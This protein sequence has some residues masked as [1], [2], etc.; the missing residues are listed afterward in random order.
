MYCYCKAIRSSRAIEASCYDDLG[1]RVIMGN[2]QPDHSTIA[3]FVTGHRVAIKDLLVQTLVIA[4]GD[5]LVSVEVVAGDGTIV[6]ANASMSSNVTADQLDLDIAELHKLLGAEVESWLGEHESN[7]AADQALFG[8]QDDD[9]GPVETGSLQRTVD[10]LLRRRAAKEQLK[11]RQDAR[12]APERERVDK[13]GANVVERERAHAEALA[14][15]QAKNQAWHARNAEGNGMPGS[16]PVQAEAHSVVRRVEETVNRAKARHA[17]AQTDFDKATAAVKI[18]TTDPGSQV[19]K[20]KHGQ[21]EQSRNVQIHVESHQLILHIACHDNSN[22]VDALHPGLRGTRDNLNAAAIT[23]PIGVAL[24][25]A[26][27]ASHENFTTNCPDAETYLLVAT[28]KEARQTGRKKDPPAREPKLDSWLAMNAKLATEQGKALY[29]KRAS[30][31]EPV[32]GQMFG[33]LG[34]YLNYRGN[35]GVDTELTLCATSHNILKILRNR[36]AIA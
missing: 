35:D 21:I 30:L 6:K 22:D 36:P 11:D 23:A 7:D 32:F 29:K 2:L 18:N 31:V 8:G 25:D 13:T 24:Y 20:G 1:S 10:T 19:M 28:T 14:H 17:K 5:G 9:D 3:R 4:A 34:R 16:R 27:Y 26:G 15:Q 33:R 12:T